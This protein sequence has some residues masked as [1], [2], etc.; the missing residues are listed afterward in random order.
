MRLTAVYIPGNSL[1]HIFGEKHEG[2]TINLGGEYFYSFNETDKEIK[3][4]SKIKNEAFIP[5]F[6]DQDIS[7]ISSIVGQNG[8]GKSTLLRTL[9]HSID[10]S[11]KK[12]VQIFENETEENIQVFNETEKVLSFSEDISVRIIDK[13]LFEP[14]YYS[15]NL[16]YDI[17][18]AWSSIALINY[19]KEDFENYFLDSVSRNVTFLHDKV[20]DSIK[21]VYHDFPDYDSIIVK[22]KNH[23]KSFFRATYIES[24]FGTPHRGDALKNEI[25]GE[26]S[27]LDDP[28]YGKESYSREELKKMMEANVKFLDSESFTEMFT[29]L[30]NIDEYKFINDTG[31]DN[32]HN[33]KNFLKN[34]EITILSYLLVGAVFP[35]H[36]LGRGLSFDKI[37]KAKTFKERL[38]LF[39][40]LY[41]INE[42][43][44]ITKKIKKNVEIDVSDIDPIVKIIIDDKF[45]KISG[46][47]LNP[48]KERMI[49]DAQGFRDIYS[50]YSTLEQFCKNENISFNGE[51]LVYNIKND[52]TKL[53]FDELIYAYKYV[54]KSFPKSPIPK[55]LLEFSPYKKLSTGEK[56]ILDFYAS[57][58][59]YIDINRESK[60]LN[61]EYFL[62]LLDEPDLGF[63]P[64]WKK[65]FIEAISA[66]LPIL[67]SKITP[68][69]YDGSNYVKVRENP[70]IQIIFT[71]HDPLTLSDIPNNSIV[72]LKK[73]GEFSKIL[74]N[75]DSERPKKTFGANI[76][77]L[78]ADSFFVEDGLIGEFAKNKIAIT[79]NWLKIKANESNELL[80]GEKYIYEIDTNIDILEFANKEDEFNYHRQII[81]LIDEPL[82][83]NKLKEM[84]IEYANDKSQFLNYELKKAKQKVQELEE[85]LKN[86]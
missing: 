19:F 40:E 2:Q 21:E 85:R 27:R 13:R 79:L 32:I 64:L 77:E 62:L 60:H 63:H 69:I 78:L 36:G 43:E 53:L 57:L 58:Y 47:D 59:N 35:Q 38:N 22:V 39:L 74:K 48:I 26:L 30:W 75:E 80:K 71:T 1:P 25:T 83:K 37:I 44:V 29:K 49:S 7:H 61:Y 4:E 76:H 24:N 8:A 42:E 72:Y 15:P 73:E 56:A 31:Y 16:D 34:S 67:F 81:E 84:F 9:N 5:N 52:E 82:V 51:S 54:L 86:A 66:T 46:V 11:S 41:L 33:G 70:I 68:H 23:R 20:V 45:S 3:I 65:K 55:S 18:D 10:P 12:V 6:Y 17:A 28:R 50:F 14:L